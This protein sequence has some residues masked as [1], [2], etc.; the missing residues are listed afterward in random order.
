M[1][2]AIFN[3]GAEG[4]RAPKL[5]DRESV[6][7]FNLTLNQCLDT[8]YAPQY[9][10]AVIQLKLSIKEAIMRFLGWRDRHAPACS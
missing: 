3:D 9:N 7:D 6:E 2:A 5:R 8:L 1:F 4:S 10:L